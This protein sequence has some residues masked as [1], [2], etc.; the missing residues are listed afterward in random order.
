MVHDAV[1]AEEMKELSLVGAIVEFGELVLASA[2][3]DHEALTAAAKIVEKEAK[4]EIGHYQSGG[5]Q[6]APWAELADYTKD[7]RVRLGFSEN[8][9]GLRNGDMRDSIGHKID[10]PILGH[11]EAVVGSNDD[12]LV[13]FELGTPHQPPRSVLGLAAHNKAPEVVEIIGGFV[14]KA[15]VGK[16]VHNGSMPIP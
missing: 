11:A 9:P 5:G 10:V 1:E 8:D 14:V 3:M 16:D 2:I 4:S 12:H 13:W 7:E 6:F 15:L